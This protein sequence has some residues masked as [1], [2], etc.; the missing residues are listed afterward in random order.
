MIDR[1]RFLLNR[2]LERLWFKPLL[3]CLLSLFGA[4]VAKAA[5]ALPQASVLPPVS[6]DS[7]ETLLQIQASSMLVIATFAVG[8]MVASYAS[9]STTATPRSFPL[10]VSDDVSQN[11]LSIFIG[12]FIFSLVSLVFLQNG[13]YAEAGRF[14]LLALTIVI[15]AIVVLTF[16]RWVDRIA[17][18]GRLGKTIETVEAAAARSLSRRRAVPRLG[19]VPIRD[20]ETPGREIR[21]DSVGYIQRIDIDRLQRLAE[22]SDRRIVLR[23]MP[24]A[25]AAPDLVLAVLPAADRPAEDADEDATALEI[26][27]AFRIGAA[28]TFDED[29]RF[30]IIALAEIAGRALSP[31]VND[32]GTAIGITGSMVRLFADWAAPRE[33]DETP[34]EPFD[35]IEVPELKADD[36]FDDAFTAI[37]RDGAGSVEVSVRLQKALA[38]LASLK[39]DGVRRA[40]HA[41]SRS[42]LARSERAM[43]SPTDIEAVRAAAAFSAA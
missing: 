32:P 38:S 20:P 25:F 19:G 39:H 15:F 16:V 30:G 14:A 41:H 23:A 9:A 5:E 42:A 40:A 11:A 26:A 2:L 18:L 13:F 36:L 8:S 10:V 3:M 33:D 29:P 43:D 1:L 22:E 35:R 7:V 28:R 4:F 17:R 12:A 37:A 6:L 21:S 27:R 34:S 31:A 24:G